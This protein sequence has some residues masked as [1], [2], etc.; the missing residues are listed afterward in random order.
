M[1]VS[2]LGCGTRG[3][4]DD[5]DD[6]AGDGDADADADT[7]SD[8][9]ADADADGDP[10][11]RCLDVNGDPTSECALSP[12]RQPC[13]L[14]ETESCAP[15]TLVEIWADDGE[16]G[17]CLR[18]LAQNDCEDVLYSWTCIEH[19][20]TEWQCWLSTTLPGF[21]VDVSECNATGRWTHY[22]SLSDGTLDVIHARCDPDP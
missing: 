8:A 21:E 11:Q 9:D 3:G 5:D 6:V 7:D 20:G 1:A 2:V 14:D 10:E 22:G 17:P 16:T 4:G 19:D 15:V 13:E 18:V 12:E